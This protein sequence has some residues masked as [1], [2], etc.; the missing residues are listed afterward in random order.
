MPKDEKKHKITF[1]ID[2][3]DD[4]YAQI[5]AKA[6][7]DNLKPQEIIEEAV[8]IYFAQLNGEKIVLDAEFLVS[9]YQTYLEDG[10]TPDAL[11]ELYPLK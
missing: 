2:L 9:A 8:E 6:D 7:H 11:R 10:I 4:E 3:T 1:T 5:I